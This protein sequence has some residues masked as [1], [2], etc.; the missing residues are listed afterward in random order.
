MVLLVPVLQLQMSTL[1][2][3]FRQSKNVFAFQVETQESLQW[4]TSVH[5]Y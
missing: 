3:L 4:A 1:T 2:L 5:Q